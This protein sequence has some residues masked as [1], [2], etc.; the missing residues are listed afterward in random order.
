MQDVGIELVSLL[1][2]LI[3]ERGEPAV[4]EAVGKAMETLRQ[5][6]GLRKMEDFLDF[7]GIR[8]GYRRSDG[9]IGLLRPALSLERML[10]SGAL[11]VVAGGVIL[12]AILLYWS[13]I[14][15]QR[16]TSVLPAVLGTTLMVLGVQNVLGGFLLAIVA[17]N[18]ADFFAG[19]ARRTQASD[20]SPP[21]TRSTSGRTK[22]NV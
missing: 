6:R 4:V 15:F 12:A 17:G 5:R 20:K 8:D 9:R 10:I 14:E 11:S 2:H 7:Y 16:I 18:D 22:L 3:Q 19:M 1:R 21:I 13:S